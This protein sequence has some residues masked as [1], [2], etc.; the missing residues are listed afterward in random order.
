MIDLHSLIDEQMTWKDDST[1]A[2]FVDS[3]QRSR[4]LLSFITILK[5]EFTHD[6]RNVW[7]F[8]EV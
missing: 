6:A 5:F 1:F 8:A 7:L 2:A 3:H 4:L